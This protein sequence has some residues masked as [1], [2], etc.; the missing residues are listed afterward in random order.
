MNAP[1]QHDIRSFI[2]GQHAD[3]GSAGISLI[4]PQD[5]AVIGHIAEAG[6][7]GVDAA[8]A[9][10]RTAF[11]GHRKTPLHARIGWLTAAA[12]ALEGSAEELAQIIC[13]DVGKPIRLA[14]FEARRGAEF[15]HATAAAASQLAGEMLPL[16]A[17]AAGANCI[18]MVRHV[19][20]G[21]VAAITPFN[22]PVNLLVQKLAPAV[23]AGNAVVAKPAPAGMRTALRLAAL[24][25]EAGWPPGLFN[26][27][28]G[29]KA[30]A[31]AL[32]A[33]PDVRAVSFT[34]GTAAGD[35][36][37]R[38]AGAKKFV[39]E[40][41]SNA[42]NIVMADADLAMAAA[43]IAGAGFEASGQQCISAQR[44][45]VQRSALDDFLPR[46]IA[47][48]RKLVVGPAA[49]GTS[50]LGPMVHQAAADRVMAM[51]ADARVHGA[52]EVLAATRD[53]ATVSPGILLD[54][55]R[56]ARLWREEVFGPIVVVVPFDT[57]D[58]AL[59]LANDSPFG[60]QGAV[61]TASLATTLRFADDFEVGSLWIN[62]A[63]RF[64]LDMYPFGGVKSSGVGR[65]GV[66]YAI[67][68]MS[69]LKFVGIRP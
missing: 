52:S 3:H 20:Y 26:V 5:G 30:T 14:R 7:E 63:S 13:E 49:D 43:K 62:E 56:E 8:V 46:L 37:A 61:F 64:R 17:T 32:V 45:L 22:A 11:A 67:E 65:E 50:D 42:A 39:A 40:L 48:T 27:L 33:H 4:R 44:I 10:A 54:V 2:G 66:R 28:T 6:A 9:A 51:V 57:V 53:G 68:E 31:I 47:A 23:A 60:L 29:D 35:A 55:S 16:D 58:E 18:G 38:A 15:M 41:G 59:A 34:G 24:F 19:P 21:V 1:V 36:L 69:Q 12:R 25:T